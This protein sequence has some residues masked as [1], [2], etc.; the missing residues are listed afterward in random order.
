[1]RIGRRTKKHEI[2]C[3]LLFLLTGAVRVCA[4]EFPAPYSAAG[5][6]A[7][8]CAVS[9][10]LVWIR[11]AQRRL[12]RDDVRRGAAAAAALMI[13]MLCAEAFGEI[14]AGGSL[15]AAVRII[16]AYC[17]LHVL[18][19]LLIFLSSLSIGERHGGKAA[20]IMFFSAVLLLLLIASNDLH[21]LF[22]VFE[23]DGSGTAVMRPGCLFILLQIWPAA[24]LTSSAGIAVSRCEVAG[25]RKKVLIPLAVITADLLYFIFLPFKDGFGFFSVFTPPVFSCA[26]YIFF[27]ESMMVTHLFP[28]ND[29]Y[30]DFWNA[31]TI[32]AGIID[33]FG[34]LRYRSSNCMPVSATQISDAADGAVLLHGGSFVLRSRK[35]RGGFGFWIRDIR[36]INRMNEELSAL[37]DVLAEENSALE[38]ENRISESRRKTERQSALYDVIAERVSPQLRKLADILESPPA[39]E[40]EFEKAMKRAC[41]FGAYVKRYSNL[42]F[43]ADGGRTMPRDELKLALAESFEYA[44]LLGC[45]VYIDCRGEE[46]ISCKNALL[47]YELFEN[48]LEAVLPE[49]AAVLADLSVSP[50]LLELHMEFS[51]AGKPEIPEKLLN[52]IRFMRGKVRLSYPDDDKTLC[53]SLAL[54]EGGARR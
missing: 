45:S 15:S 24:L 18:I 50:E 25:S 31:S 4:F 54:P 28:S 1:M 14:F 52:E 5:V 49:T 22:F 35:V 37:G 51:G 7:F 44:R 48:I 9:A 6:P 26:A 21:S 20:R 3:V 16:Y 46:I 42:A 13:L 53:V 17:I 29:G 36:D 10:V 32:A 40:D 12:R 23:K 39:D 47:A 41:V 27:F 33:D 11:Q 8:A 19:S 38:A 43:L 2:V 30:G 34:V